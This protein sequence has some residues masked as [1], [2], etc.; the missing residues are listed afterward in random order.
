M[1]GT[2]IA[3]L[4]GAGQGRFTP[5]HVGN[6][7]EPVDQMVVQAVHPHACGEHNICDLPRS[8]TRG[9]PPRM[10]GTRRCRLGFALPPRFTPTH[11][12]NTLG[13]SHDKTPDSVHP[14]A[15][16]EHLRSGRCRLANNGSPPRMWGTRPLAALGTQDSRF[17][18]THVGNTCQSGNRTNFAK[19][20]PHACGEHVA[21]QRTGPGPHGSPPRMWGTPDVAVVAN[22][23][24]R[25]TPTHVGNTLPWPGSKVLDT[26][27]PHA[28][29]E[30]SATNTTT[31]LVN[32]SP[33]R[34][35]G[36]PSGGHPA[37]WRYRFTPTHVGNTFSSSVRPRFVPG[38][39]PR[40]WGTLAPRGTDFL[41]CRFTPT[42]VGNTLLLILG[43][44]GQAVHPHACGEHA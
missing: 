13:R 28:C 4:A 41:R 43:Q 36:T 19:I 34:M 5:T 22:R 15:C 21:I 39:P 31:G 32:G 25:F 33:P 10:W 26:V 24:Q 8:R 1:W 30:H 35:W 18:P 29:G 14:H 42:H 9:S 20:H 23:D 2:R 7:S 16:G 11:V 6:T 38:S 37:Q 44:H 27:H 17:T 40:M 12:G 3:L